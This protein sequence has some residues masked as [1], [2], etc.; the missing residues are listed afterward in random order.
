MRSS[1]ERRPG[2][3]PS[4]RGTRSTSS[5]ASRVVALVR[6]KKGSAVVLVGTRK[7]GFIF[8]SS[9]RRMW[10]MMGP[11]MEGTSVY[12]T[13]LDPRDGRTVYAAARSEEHTSELQS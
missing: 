13:I 11:F 7:G 10:S 3:S 8:H 2:A 6:V 4:L 12:H 9:D 5:P 1:S